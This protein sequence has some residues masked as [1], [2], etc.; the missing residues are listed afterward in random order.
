MFDSRGASLVALLS[1]VLV[2]HITMHGCKATQHDSLV[3]AM[4]ANTFTCKLQPSPT[5]SADACFLGATHVSMQA[6]DVSSVCTRKVQM[7][8]STERQQ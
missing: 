3:R 6:A 1:K 4:V 8:C 7:H 5:H 2:V